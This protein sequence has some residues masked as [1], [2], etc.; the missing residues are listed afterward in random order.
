MIDIVDFL[1]Y[2][3]NALVEAVINVRFEV[4][5]HAP[6]HGDSRNERWRHPKPKPFSGVFCH[7]SYNCN[8]GGL[9]ALQQIQVSVD[10]NQYQVALGVVKFVKDLKAALSGGNNL[11]VAIAIASAALT[12]LAPVLP[13]LAPAQGE[14]AFDQN[15]IVTA[16]VVG[17]LLLQAL[18]S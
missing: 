4:S 10:Q 7:P 1:L 18:K 11:T 2:D 6:D 16:G 9:M 12:D 8:K 5:D 3:C 14:V 15:E 13:Q 17:G